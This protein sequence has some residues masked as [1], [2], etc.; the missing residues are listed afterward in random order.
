L[1]SVRRRGRGCG[2]QFFL[3]KGRNNP[4]VRGSLRAIHIKPVCRRAVSNRRKEMGGG[5]E[6][7]ECLD[8]NAHFVSRKDL[9]T[10]KKTRSR[11]KKILGRRLGGTWLANSYSYKTSAKKRKK[12]FL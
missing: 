2:S 3:K 4:D 8:V 6:Q 9:G 1:Q 5:G 7:G 11:R 10:Q 12:S